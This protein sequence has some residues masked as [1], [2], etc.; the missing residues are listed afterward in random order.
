MKQKIHFALLS[1]ALFSLVFTGFSS[2]PPAFAQTLFT[3]N[4]T[5][6]DGIQ[7]VRIIDSNGDV[8]LIVPID[9]CPNS[10][11][12]S[13]VPEEGETYSVLWITCRGGGGLIPIDMTPPDSGTDTDDDTVP[14][15]DDNCPTVP[16]PDQADVDGDGIGDACDAFQDDPDNDIDK[17]GLGANED[18][19]PT[20]NNPDQ[21]DSDSD[22]TGDACDDDIDGD[23]VPNSTDNC[24]LTPNPD[25]TD[26]D[27]DGTGDACDD[28]PESLTGD[29]KKSCDKLRENAEKDNGNQKGITKNALENNSC[30]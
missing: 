5:D 26:S 18:N 23:T 2:V 24:P 15:V 7:E 25:Q 17:D 22:G 13:F 14:D 11:S 28:T 19:C 27:S 20:T 30:N 10:T 29:E 21:T 8:F 4:V 16:N 12:V 1:L 9:G 6:P 3:V